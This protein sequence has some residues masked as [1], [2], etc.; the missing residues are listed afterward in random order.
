MQSTR[1]IN[2]GQCV[3]S[4][5]STNTI[6]ASSS[7]L[8]DKKGIDCQQF[9]DIFRLNSENFG[10]LN[11]DHENLFGK[12]EIVEII[13]NNTQYALIPRDFNDQNAI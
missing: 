11:S 9:P 6:L 2:Y 8:S 13:Q 3:K 10:F 4:I 7:A 5:L 12:A 1:T